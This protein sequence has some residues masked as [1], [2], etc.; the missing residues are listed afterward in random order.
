MERLPELQL[1][2]VAAVVA[3]CSVGTATTGTIVLDAVRPPT[4]ISS[5]SSDTELERVEKVRGPRT[6]DVLIVE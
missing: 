5:A 2:E 1:D 6:L 3:G 4:F